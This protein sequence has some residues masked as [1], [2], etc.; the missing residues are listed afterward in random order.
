MKI[1]I[2]FKAVGAMDARYEPMIMQLQL[3]PKSADY[4]AITERLIDVERRIGASE[5]AK[6]GALRTDTGSKEPKK[7]FKGECFYCKK[8]GHRQADCRTRLSDEKAGKGPSTGP[9]ATPSGGKGLSPT[10][11]QAKTA[12]EVCWSA[13]TN[14]ERQRLVWVIDS[15]CSRHMTFLRDAFTDYTLLDSP[16]PVETASGTEILGVGVGSVVL[17]IDIEGQARK[18]RLTD[19]L[20]VPSVAGS[21]ISVSQLEDRGITIRTLGGPKRGLI[22]ELNGS[23]VAEASR[24]GK[25][26][27][28]NCISTNKESALIAS[29]DDSQVWHQ[30][31]G[32]FSID[33][34]RGIEKVTTGRKDPIRGVKS[35]VICDLTKSIRVIN[36]G[37][38]ERSK[39]PLDRIYSDIWGPYKVPSIGGVKYFISFTDDYSRKSWIFPT[40]T[41]DDLYTV[42]RQFRALR[43]LESG[44]KIKVMR[45]DNGGEYRKLGDDMHRQ[46]GIKFE[47]TTVYTPEQ[48]G[49][50][51]RLNR[52][53]VQLARGMLLD[54]QLPPWMWVYAIET[55]CYIRNRTP[56]GP[57]GMTPEEA[58]CG[59]KPNIGHLRVFGCLAYAHIPQKTR[60]KL[61]NSA[62]PTCL[63]GYMATSRQYQLYE[64]IRRDIIVST[65][66]TFHEHERLEHNWGNK[67]AGELVAPFDPMRAPEGDDDFPDEVDSDRGVAELS[68]RL[69]GSVNLNSTTP[70]PRAS[71]ASG[72]DMVEVS[73]RGL[74]NQPENQS[75]RPELNEFEAD[76]PGDLYE[77]SPE[78][79]VD[80]GDRLPRSSPDEPV[81]PGD[82]SLLRASPDE[83]EPSETLVDGDTIEVAVDSATDDE[84]EAEDMEP[85]RSGR[86]RVPTTRY[87]NNQY[88][89][90]RA[91]EGVNI[92]KTYEAAVSDQY[93]RANWEQAIKEELGKLQ[94][95]DTWEYA[96]LPPGKRTVDTK[97]VF[98][99]KY[100]P[101][102]LI[103]RYKA[104][105][106][107]RGF[108]QVAG[109]DYLETFSPT[110]RS[111][112][113]RILLAIGASEDLEIRQL[114]VVSAYPRS[115][116]HAEVYMRAPA[117]LGAPPGKVL[118][119]K[120]SLYGLKQSGREWYIEAA[121][122]LDKLGFKPCYSE[123]SIFVNSDRSQ[124]IGVYVDD[125]LVLGADLAR[126]K[127]TIRR[128]AERWE[129]KD[130]G[131]V[132]Q[133]LGIQV[134][135]DRQKRTLRLT[136]EPYIRA[137]AREF[138][139][140]GSKT[141]NTPISD[142]NTITG[143]TKDE[144]QADQSLYQ[145]GVGSIMWAAKGSRLD[146]QYV[147]GQLS[148]YC[149]NPT[150]RHWNAI[151]RVV[152]YLNSTADYGIE[153]GAGGSSEHQLQGYSDADYAGD[154]SD[155]RSV[156]GY[157]FILGGGPITWTSI[158]QRSVSTSTTES[159]YMALSEACKQGYWIRALLGELDRY[160]YL[161]KSRATPIFSDNQSCIALAK[162]PIAHSRTKHIDVRYHYIRELVSFDKTT[163]D[164]MPTGDMKADILTKPLPFTTFK[165]C[166]EGLLG[167]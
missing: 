7:R 65:A 62:I 119:L 34:I 108:T 14:I 82:A 24:I 45:C 161:P 116:L 37:A 61:E 21:L 156:S 90:Y 2:L 4:R 164:Y 152:R 17:N 153:Y 42:F 125:M 96:D 55:A 83:L 88:K 63:V 154:T 155:R 104:R 150:I 71:E 143:A 89:A 146:V 136:Q 38:P 99:V 92:P 68:E 48:N 64:P 70:P 74:Q 140:E 127:E 123:P 27:V 73:E 159:E 160:Q 148:Q 117:A 124:I 113:V 163:I 77:R 36:R 13:N 87:P 162:D 109:D 23:A 31:F 129:I 8:K 115:E 157:L 101:T 57:K 59:Q 102:G 110:I 138:G 5:P 151:L 75:I 41:K 95:L 98:T 94:A 85:R 44:R 80:P 16:V 1:A 39:K 33:T 139:L 53:L 54:A 149:N 72:G 81:D 67:E 145:R 56:I 76:E 79:N 166:I 97:W 20:H 137:L 40:K 86:A 15:G 28:L 141:I 126:V 165:R 18:V 112:S 134:S 132:A 122:G 105:L 29:A 50:S 49:V 158:K 52:T 47:Y 10:P 128:I 144:A 12:S 106:V 69:R 30:R 66:P 114:D 43:E 130:L 35:C 22:I 93:H 120:K 58:Y 118:K 135:R 51:E 78:E 131:D 100:T 6:E 111:E 11:E 142:R 3:S 121:K 19:V 26:Y 167:P 32:H 60:E 107:A 91:T 46:Y 133:I 9:L 147:I 25:S 103:D 84:D